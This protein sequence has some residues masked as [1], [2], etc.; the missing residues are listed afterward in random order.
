MYT[1]NDPQLSLILSPNALLFWFGTSATT[2]PHIHHSLS[3][4]MIMSRYRGGR[5]GGKEREREG[6][7]KGGREK[8]RVEGERK[9]GFLV[10]EQ[11]YPYQPTIGNRC[12]YT[13]QSIHHIIYCHTNSSTSYHLPSTRQTHIS[14]NLSQPHVP[15]PCNRK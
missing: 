4:K 10:M 14:P 3:P 13:N 9:G 7:R 6:K 2:S 5:E 1:L 15:V 11:D 12:M 8:W